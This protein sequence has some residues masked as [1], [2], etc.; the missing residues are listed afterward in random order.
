MAGAGELL[1]GGKAGWAGADDRDLLA[2]AGLRR[3]G[4][5]PALVPGAVD[6]GAFDRLDGDRRVLDVQ[7]AGR[8]AGGGADAAGEL[9][10]IVGRVK[11]DRRLAPAAV[12][13]ES[14]QSGSGC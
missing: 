14:F 2:G 1:G 11:V 13:D 10:E 3:L 5:D 9:G 12:V 8:L 7:R 6:D 4:R